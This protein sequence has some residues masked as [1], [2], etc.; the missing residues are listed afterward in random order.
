MLGLAYVFKYEKLG[1]NKKAL[2]PCPGERRNEGC[3]G[4]HLLSTETFLWVPCR[5]LQTPLELRRFPNLGTIIT[6]DTSFPRVG[7]VF[8][9]KG[10]VMEAV[11]SSFHR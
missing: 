5:W 6:R 9:P 11:L 2:E 3:D 4:T 1:V 10:A 8:S 7:S